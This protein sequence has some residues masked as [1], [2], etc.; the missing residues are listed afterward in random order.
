MPTK[1]PSSIL[2]SRA[3]LS[4]PAW[5]Q[6]AP[7]SAASRMGVAS[8]IPLLSSSTVKTLKN[9]SM[10]AALSFQRRASSAR[11]PLPRPGDILF[12]QFSCCHKQDDEANDRAS[13]LAWNVQ[14]E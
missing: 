14:V 6:I 5:L 10:L 12:I 8:R 3:R 2:L 9:P 7:P 13:Q 1:A 11:G 4:T